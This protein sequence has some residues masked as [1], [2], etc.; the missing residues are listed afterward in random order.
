MKILS[1]SLLYGGGSCWWEPG[2]EEE[3]TEIT[4]MKGF[5]ELRR[6]WVITSRDGG[7]GDSSSVQNKSKY[8]KKRDW[9]ST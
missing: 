1:I 7:H 5:E 6:I 4:K 2:E 3:K 8:K 9:R